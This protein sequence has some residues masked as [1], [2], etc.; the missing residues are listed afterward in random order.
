MVSVVVTVFAGSAVPCHW[1]CVLAP[2]VLEYLVV[3]RLKCVRLVVSVL[4]HSSYWRSLVSVY[5]IWYC[6][7]VF[8]WNVYRPEVLPSAVNSLFS[9][10]VL[11]GDCLVSSL[12]GST[13]WCSC[14]GVGFC[15]NLSPQCPCLSSG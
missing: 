4:V 14:S 10:L 11:K 1:R 3:A 15:R 9:L 2:T 5:G 8:N 6:A 13:A 12:K 7:F